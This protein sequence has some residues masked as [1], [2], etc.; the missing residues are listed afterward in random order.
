MTVLSNKNISKELIYK[1]IAYYRLSKEDR[2]KTN[3]SLSDSIENQRKLVQEYAKAEGIEIVA[4]EIDD[5]YSGVSYDRPGFQNVLKCLEEGKANTVIVKDLSRLGREYIETGRYIEMMFPQMNVR[6]IA[7]NDS[8]D[9]NHHNSSD[10]LLIPMKN[11][12]NENYCRELS[13]KLRKQ[14]KI[15]RD[16]GEFINN[17]AP[18]GYMRDPED[19]H[20]LVIDDVASEVVSGIYELCLHGYSPSRIADYL[21][22]HD[23]MSPYDYKKQ[24]SNYTSGF[25]GAGVGKWNPTTVKRILTNSVYTGE[26]CQGK[27]TTVSYKVKQVRELDREEW[28]VVEDAHD[29]IIPICIFE[30]VQKLLSRDTRMSDNDKE[31]Q[32]LAG[33]VF[34]GDCGKA[35]CRRTVKRGGKTFHY[36]W[37][38]TYKR[39]K[40]CTTH[41]ISQKSLE[42]VVLH[43]LQKQIEVLVEMSELL[44]DIDKQELSNSKLRRIDS[45][46]MQKEQEL[47]KC[48]NSSMKLYDSYVEELITRDDYKMMKQKYVSRIQEIEDSIALLI[49]DREKVERNTG[50]SVSWIDRFLKYQG[51]QELSHEVVATLI[52]RVEVFEGKRIQIVFNFKNQ[53]DEL[54]LYIEGM[55]KEA[56]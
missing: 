4:E 54:L 16:N 1:A 32:A 47:E 48:H 40:G 34:C 49:E 3:I 5:G 11:L 44:S 53:M 24:T 51:L 42:D 23:I 12:M 14:F 30:V 19:K 38:G 13:R 31:V 6:F 43:S 45:M 50:D 7:I 22:E 33:F 35:L 36:Y 37:C 26:L 2:N 9:S 10:D 8:V 41:N 18:Y 15:Q 21:N 17:F 27:T 29:A 39:G 25:K 20:K 28:S 52:D 55:K 56:I 46:I